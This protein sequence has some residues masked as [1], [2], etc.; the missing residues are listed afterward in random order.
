MIVCKSHRFRENNMEKEEIYTKLLY[1]CV[2]DSLHSNS[3]E[4]IKYCID[5]GAD[6]NWKDIADNTALHYAC[7]NCGCSRDIQ[8]ELIKFLL[9]QGA[10]VNITNKAGDTPLDLLCCINDDYLAVMPPNTSH[11]FDPELIPLLESYAKKGK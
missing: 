4:L 8:A 6:I 7:D 2:R 11:C 3:L 9:E 10:D 1:S 5:N